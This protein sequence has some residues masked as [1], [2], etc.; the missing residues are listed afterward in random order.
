VNFTHSSAPKGIDHI[1]GNQL[2]EVNHDLDLLSM[3]TSPSGELW[4]TGANG[5]FR[6]SAAAFRQNQ[7]GQET[8]PDYAWFGKSDG[9]A[10]AQCSTGA[11]NMALTPD[12]KL[13]VATVQGLAMLDRNTCPSTVLSPLFSLKTSPLD[14]YGSSPAMNLCYLPAPIH[15]ELSFRFHFSGMAR[16]NSLQYRMDDVDPLWLE[17]DNSL[18]AVYTNIP[19]R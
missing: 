12:G 7:V 14:E 5:I 11:P 4:F 19:V 6:F 18:T 2:V 10:S 13:W 1:T 16:K 3:A 8:T 15:V 17:A 9:M